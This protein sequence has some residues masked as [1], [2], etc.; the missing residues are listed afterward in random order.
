MAKPATLFV[1]RTIASARAGL[2]HK[3]TSQLTQHSAAYALACSSCTFTHTQHLWQPPLDIHPLLYVCGGPSL[4]ASQRRRRR[5]RRSCRRRAAPVGSSASAARAGPPWMSSR[6]GGSR[7]RA[8]RR[9][10]RH[11]HRQVVQ[12]F[13]ERRLSMRSIPRQLQTQAHPN[14]RRQCRSEPTPCRACGRSVAHSDAHSISR[15][16]GRSV[17]R[18]NSQRGQRDFRRFE[19]AT[20]KARSV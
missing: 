16:V 8:L 18:S 13:C 19:S 20:H 9:A 17:D 11:Q 7:L 12:R 2:L 10:S 3:Q 6:Y 1:W 5:R 15:S 14:H 4:N